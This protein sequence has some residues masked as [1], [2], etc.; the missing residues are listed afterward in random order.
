MSFCYWFTD[1][2]ESHATYAGMMLRDTLGR[3]GGKRSDW[4]VFRVM[5]TSGE[6]ALTGFLSTFKPGLKRSGVESGAR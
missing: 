6:A 5:T 4:M 3:L 1:G 2:T